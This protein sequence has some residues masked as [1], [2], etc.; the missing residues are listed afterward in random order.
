MITASAFGQG[1]FSFLE[2]D[3]YNLL[4]FK[5]IFHKK[6]RVAVYIDANNF[7]KY[8]K[9]KQ[10]SFPKGV[11]FNYPKFIDFLV[12]GRGLISKRY[13]V[14]IARN[15][16]NSAKSKEMVKGQQKFLA[17]LENQNFVIKR[18]RLMYDGNKIR[19]KG[20][21]VKIAVDLVVGSAD[22][23]YDTAILISS[24]TDL[25]PAVKYLKYKGK[26]LEYIGFSHA[27][28]FGLQKFADFSILLTPT[29]IEN[30][31]II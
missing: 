4:M 26:K 5:G 12:K 16:D 19:E 28:S 27:P 29:D 18:G 10:I 15:I 22:N 8:L 3:C 24:D 2:I 25:I 11:K 6:E 14:G 31:K 9:D 30:F 13:Y 1:Q 20:T 23:M 17:A 21:D 7:F